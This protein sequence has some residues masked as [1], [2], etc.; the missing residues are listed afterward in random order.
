MKID[1]CV[2]ME[3]N[4]IMSTALVHAWLAGEDNSVRIPVRTVPLD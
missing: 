1:A 3:L 4:A 2:K